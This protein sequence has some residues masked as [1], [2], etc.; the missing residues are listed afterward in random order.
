MI[1]SFDELNLNDTLRKILNEA[2][3]TSPSVL[4]ALSWDEIQEIGRKIGREQVVCTAVRLVRS[5]LKRLGLLDV[6]QS[7][8]QSKNGKKKYGRHAK[9]DKPLTLDSL[10]LTLHSKQCLRKAGITTVPGL[11]LC[12]EAQLKKIHTLGRKEVKDIIGKMKNK[13]LHLRSA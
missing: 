6:R 11:M 10:G 5:K 13:G 9:A 7:Q 2:G 8:E 1:N 12:T 4:C 3:L